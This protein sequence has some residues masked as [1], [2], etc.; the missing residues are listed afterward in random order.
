MR[1]VFVFVL[2][3]V[4]I[5]FVSYWNFVR[6]IFVL[7]SLL[8]SCCTIIVSALRSSWF[9]RY[10][11][12]VRVVF[13]LRWCC[14]GFCIEM[15]LCFFRIGLVHYSYCMSAKFVMY[16]VC[17]GLS[18]V[19]ISELHQLRTFIPL[20]LYSH[21]VRV[22]SCVCSFVVVLRSCCIPLVEVLCSV[23]FV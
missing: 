17:I 22:V 9:R 21:S 11:N 10:C 7:I 14:I 1:I 8:S 20:P 6:I 18:F 4:R 12:C 13:V 3:C 5:A 15:S 19:L 2:Y 23:V 16:C